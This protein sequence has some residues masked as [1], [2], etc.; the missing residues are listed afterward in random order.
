MLGK[1]LPDRGEDELGLQSVEEKAEFNPS[2]SEDW[3]SGDTVHQTYRQGRR[4][5][6]DFKDIKL[7]CSELIPHYF[8]SNNNSV[9]STLQGV[10]QWKTFM[11]RFKKKKKKRKA[12][13]TTWCVDEKWFLILQ[14][15]NQPTIN[16]QTHL[17]QHQLMS[18]HL[19]TQD[20]SWTLRHD[21]GSQQEESVFTLHRIHHVPVRWTADQPPSSVSTCHLAARNYMMAKKQRTDI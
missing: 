14:L 8:I 17:L 18:R 7:K 6:F 19:P 10:Q 1:I 12:S 21:T 9:G 11:Q 4:I 16:V 5:H 2:S 3:T 20:P 15:P 13:H